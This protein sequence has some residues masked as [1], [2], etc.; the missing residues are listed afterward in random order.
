MRVVDRLDFVVAGLDCEV[1]GLD[2]C[3]AE[4]GCTVDVGVVIGEA[5][6]LV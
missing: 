5:E 6:A 2:C 3:K 4:L 1:E